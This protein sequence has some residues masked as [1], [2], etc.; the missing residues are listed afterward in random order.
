MNQMRN[1]SA[2]G[3]I[4]V[5]FSEEHFGDFAI[6]ECLIYAMR[7][8]AIGLDYLSIQRAICKLMN[9]NIYIPDAE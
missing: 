7:L 2:H 8:R 3:N 9:Y 5:E 4:D 1:D 6:L